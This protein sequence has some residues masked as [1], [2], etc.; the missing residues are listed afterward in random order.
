MPRPNSNKRSISL[1]EPLVNFIKKYLEDHKINRIK[2]GKDTTIVSVIREG[3]FLWAEKH[4][5]LDQLLKYL[6]QTE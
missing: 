2:D 4:G 5:V 6:Q 3:L 1:D